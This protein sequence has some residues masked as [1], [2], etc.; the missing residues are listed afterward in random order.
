MNNEQETTIISSYD[1]NTNVFIMPIE[2]V[3]RVN[4]RGTVVTGC[5]KEGFLRVGEE[6]YLI[7]SF[8]TKHKIT[9]VGIEMFRKLVDHV[10]RVTMLGFF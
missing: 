10:R 8:G 6:L 9:C 3:F 1:G 2:D 4:G 5:V 7:D